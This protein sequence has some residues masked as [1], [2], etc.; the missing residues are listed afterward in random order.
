[1]KILLDSVAFDFIRRG[2]LYIIN[3]TF[4]T[5]RK[6]NCR[7]LNKGNKSIDDQLTT[8]YEITKIF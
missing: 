1:M 7:K 5:F 6:F 8:R 3:D 4:V 2:N